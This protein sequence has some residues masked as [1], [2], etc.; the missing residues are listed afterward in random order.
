M[1]APDGRP[2][3]VGGF[4]LTAAAVTAAL[5]FKHWAVT[6]IAV[7]CAVLTG[8]LLYFFRD[9]DRAAPQEAGAVVAPADGWVVTVSEAHGHPFVGKNASRLAIFLSIF[10][11][12][13]NR[14]PSS[15]RVDYVDYRPGSFKAAFVATAG[16][17]NEQTEIGLTAPSGVRLAFRQIAGL[18]ARRVVCRLQAGQDVVA[19]ERCGIIKFG[20]RADVFLPHG[21]R[22]IVKKGDH[23][24]AGRTVLA[25]LSTT[26]GASDEAEDSRK[27]DA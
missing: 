8:F 10:D 27:Q 2:L 9:P 13:V 18:L 7:L 23:V 5:L 12:H 26:P 19:G 16:D 11:V 21:S 22:I 20:S 6:A 25:Y 4:I 17:T 24:A 3:I 1:I 15:G 14:T